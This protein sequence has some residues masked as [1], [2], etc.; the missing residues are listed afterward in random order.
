MCERERE[1]ERKRERERENMIFSCHNTHLISSLFI[2]EFETVIFKKG[3]KFDK[4][5]KDEVEYLGW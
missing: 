1:R 3:V 2:V 4:I 5:S